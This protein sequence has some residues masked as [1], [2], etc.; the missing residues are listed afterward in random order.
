[1]QVVLPFPIYILA[2]CKYGWILTIWNSKYKDVILEPAK[3]CTY[4]VCICK[5]LTVF[6]YVFC[7]YVKLLHVFARIYA[8]N[9]FA[10]LK[11]VKIRAIRAKLT[12]IR[13]YT[14][15]KYLQIHQLVFSYWKYVYWRYMIVHACIWQYMQASLNSRLL[16]WL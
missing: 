16:E 2:S 1:M 8:T 7:Q 10:C 5:Y 14:Y 9:T 4:L 13:A 15:T 6:W 3:R 12:T 11:Y